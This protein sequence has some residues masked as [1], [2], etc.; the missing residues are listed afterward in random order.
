MVPIK[1]LLDINIQQHNLMIT[2]INDC[3]FQSK[4]DK[5]SIYLI[6]KSNL[7]LSSGKFLSTLITH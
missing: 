5:K 6:D 3:H 4:Q 7:H 1:E 2:R